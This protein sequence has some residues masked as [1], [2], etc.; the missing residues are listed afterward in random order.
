MAGNRTTVLFGTMIVL[1]LS[2][3]IS[4]FVGSRI[5]SPA[6]IAI[7]TAPPTPSPIL[8]P[9]E[10]RKLSV[11]IVTRGTARF[12]LPQPFTIV[13]SNLKTGPSL[14]ATLPKVNSQL[15]EGQVVL[16]ASGRPV[17][18]LLGKTPTYRDLSPGISGDDVFQLERRL[19][20]LG[21]SPGKVDGLYDEKTSRAVSAWYR[22]RNWEPFSSTKR[23]LAD[24]RSLE[25]DLVQAKKQKL[26]TAAALSTA[27]LNIKSVGD[28]VKHNQQAAA[29][30]LASAKA[31]Y[32]LVSLDPRQTNTVRK[33]AEAKLA[34]AEASARKAKSDGEL[35][36]RTAKD[37]MM[38]A[39]LE[40][41]IAKDLVKR[42]D[43]DMTQA[44][45]KLGI[46]I[47]ADELVFVP[48]LPAR[49]DK[50]SVAVGEPAVGHIMSITDNVLSIDSSLSLDVAPLVKPGLKVLIDEQNLGIKS[51]GVISKVAANPGSNGVDAYHIYFEVRVTDNPS[52]LAGFSV[53]ITIPLKSTNGKVT[54]VPVSALSLS[55]DGQSR[56]Q[57]EGNGGLEYVVVNP[58]MAAD[59][60]VE[61]SSADANLTP[62]QMV[63]IGYNN[64]NVGIE[65]E[66]SKSN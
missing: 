66:T 4:W 19:K 40:S 26:A 57:V 60:Y 31:D 3:G 56:I 1:S 25:Q 65:S 34:L 52:N 15:K 9:I 35:A 62:G 18:L 27:K 10:S 38:L 7:R 54:A 45:A 20:R 29:V 5:E 49:V 39:E 30:E 58:G 59:G 16:T 41:E 43:A 64:P 22:A 33:A 50:I 32:A 42:L 53:R 37:A 21:F 48:E 12:G 28:N 6:D 23:Q 17:M 44:K 24:F 14:I 55:T 8:V 61:V 47:P 11:N 46:Q 13:P 63:V 36:I 2:A 51:K